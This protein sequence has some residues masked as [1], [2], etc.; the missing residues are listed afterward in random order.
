[1]LSRL[2]LICNHD[3]REQSNAMKSQLFL[4]IIIYDHFA[5]IS[6]AVESHPAGLAHP[7]HKYFFYSIQMKIRQ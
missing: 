2:V 7:D 6:E 5:V 1:M 4:N 3:N